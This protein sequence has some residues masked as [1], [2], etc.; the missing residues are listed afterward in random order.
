MLTAVPASNALRTSLRNRVSEYQGAGFDQPSK[1]G[2]WLTRSRVSGPGSTTVSDLQ[3][4]GFSALQKPGC[5]NWFSALFACFLLAA[6]TGAASA[7]EQ[8]TGEQIYRKQCASCHG[9]NGE[10]TDEYFPRALT[11]DRS[12]AQL[13][14]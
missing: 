3:K 12:V 8:K 10:G 14:R 4:P 9:K 7:E 1:P 2:C 13:T 5:G 11:G 6:W